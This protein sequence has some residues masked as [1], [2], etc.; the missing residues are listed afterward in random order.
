VAEREDGA[1]SSPPPPVNIVEESLGLEGIAPVAKKRTFM[2]R[3]A[4]SKVLEQQDESRTS[5][6]LQQKEEHAQPEQR[7]IK[8]QPP[9][10]M[11]PVAAPSSSNKASPLVSSTRPH[12]QPV[13]LPAQAE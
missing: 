4:T 2:Q 9:P 6:P 3:R 5:Q 7:S 8:A 12:R 1:P 13:A 10:A 11:V